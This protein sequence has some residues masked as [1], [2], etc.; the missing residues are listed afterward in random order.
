MNH[1]EAEINQFLSKTA[2]CNAK[3]Y[4]INKM[5]FIKINTFKFNYIFLK[6]IKIISMYIKYLAVSRIDD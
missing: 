3:L 5:R 1:M 2:D 4:K 6:N